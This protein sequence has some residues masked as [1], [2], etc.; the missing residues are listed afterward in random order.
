[1]RPGWRLKRLEADEGRLRWVLSSDHM[2]ELLRMGEDEAAIVQMLDGETSLPE[3]MAE[4]ERRYGDAGVTRLAGLLATLGERGLLEG[5]EGPRRTPGRAG[6]PASPARA[7][8]RSPAPA[9]SSSAST[10]AGA[11][12]SSPA[13]ASS[14]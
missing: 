3:L 10:A 1:M 9:P 7:S 14:C 2:P 13:R 6:W 11:G 12:C 4:A 8:A 5:V